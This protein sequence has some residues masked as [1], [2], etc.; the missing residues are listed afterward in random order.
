MATLGNHSRTVLRCVYRCLPYHLT[1]SGEGISAKTFWIRLRMATVL[2]CLG[3]FRGER[4]NFGEENDQ[5]EKL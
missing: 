5:E 4:I 2:R 3:D 1:P